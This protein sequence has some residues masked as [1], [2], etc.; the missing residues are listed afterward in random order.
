MRKK[1]DLE[2]IRNPMDLLSARSAKENRTKRYG[3]VCEKW[4]LRIVSAISE[5]GVFLVTTFY[6]FDCDEPYFARGKYGRNTVIIEKKD[7]PLVVPAQP[8][9]CC[10]TLFVVRQESQELRAHLYMP[11]GPFDDL[12]TILVHPHMRPIIRIEIY[13]SLDEWDGETVCCDRF[14][15]EFNHQ[16]QDVNVTPND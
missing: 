7:S 2:K 5:Q 16:Y 3:F 12:K 1:I 15:V 9:G 10:G 11:T 8:D 13:D 4:M 6:E 14:S